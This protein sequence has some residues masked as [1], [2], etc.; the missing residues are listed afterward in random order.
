[1]FRNLFLA[2][3]LTLAAA[4]A[5]AA[6]LVNINGEQRVIYDEPSQNVVG[7]GAAAIVGEAGSRHVVYRGATQAQPGNGEVARLEN[8]NG[9]Q[10]VV[11]V[12]AARPAAQLAGAFNGRG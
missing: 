9:E 6:E 4:G 1:M 12:P 10:R 7:G 11:H 3:A 2:S 8:I 5:Q